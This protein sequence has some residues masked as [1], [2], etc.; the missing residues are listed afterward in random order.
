MFLWRTCHLN[1]DSVCVKSTG[2]TLKISQNR[3]V[4]F[5]TQCVV[6]K[7]KISRIE[8]RITKHEV[9]LI[10]RHWRW[11]RQFL[12]NIRW[13]WTDY[14]PLYP[15]PQNYSTAAMR[16]SNPTVCSYVL[17]LC[18]PSLPNVTCQAP[19]AQFL[20]SSNRN[21]NTSSE[22]PPSFII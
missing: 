6:I 11:R 22:Q 2:P 14:T 12:R 17:A 15:M 19:L 8:L 21:L 7:V 3:H 13:F 9:W 4:A 10:L 20:S 16:I 5:Y 1:I 18:S